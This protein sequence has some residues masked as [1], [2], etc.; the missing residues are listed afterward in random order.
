MEQDQEARVP[1]QAEVWDREVARV[2]AED[3]L[4]VPVDIVSAQV[5]V[6]RLHT[7]WVPPVMSGCVRSVEQP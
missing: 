4:P 6:K 2:E 5:A 3:L 1:E 7:N